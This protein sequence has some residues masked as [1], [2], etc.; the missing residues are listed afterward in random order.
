MRIILKLLREG[1]GRIIILV[2]YLTRPTP[3]KRSKPEQTK[4]N[5]QLAHMALYQFYA[6]PFCIKTRRALRRLNLPMQTRNINEGSPFRAELEKAT[7]RVKAPCLRVQEGEQVRWLFES[8]DIIEYLE[9]R[10]DQR[11]PAA[12]IKSAA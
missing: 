2:D 8:N 4:V 6:C 7:G 11:P 5:A 1:L 9:K 12:C 10:F 3:L